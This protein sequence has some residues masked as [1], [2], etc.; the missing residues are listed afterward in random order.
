MSFKKRHLDYDSIK[1]IEKYLGKTT[2]EIIDDTVPSIIRHENLD[3]GEGLT[4]EEFLSQFKELMDLNEVGKSFIGQGYHASH[5]PNVIKR[6]VLE[7][8]SI[9]REM[10]RQYQPAFD[11]AF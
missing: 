2:K 1:E 7:N 6:N 11:N 10:A 9:N 5:L 4:E 8:N 3:L